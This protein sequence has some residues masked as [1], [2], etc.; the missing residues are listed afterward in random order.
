VKLFDREAVEET[1]PRV[2]IG[3]RQFVNR[4][5][6]VQLTRTWFADYS[7]QG[8]ST[9]VA[10]KTQSK[11]V[12]IHRAHELAAKLRRDGAPAPRQN[13][14]LT[15]L[16]RQYLTAQ[17][18]K[19]R[20]SKT[21]EKYTFVLSAFVAWASEHSSGQASSMTEDLFWQWHHGLILGGYKSSTREDHLTLVKQL[22]KWAAKTKRMERNPIE[23]AK[24]PQGE[25]DPQPCFE[26]AQVA[27]L[28]ERADAFERPLF[29]TLAYTGVRIGE[30]RDL[31]WQDVV[32]PPDRAG[33]ILVRSGG[34]DGT[35]KNRK[36]RRIPIAPELRPILEAMPRRGPRVFY[37]PPSKRY[38]HGDCPLNDS[39]VLQ[40]L[41]DL[42]ERC[43]FVDP[44]Q[45]KV[46]T[47]RHVFAS[48]CARNNV[49]YKYALTWL[50]HGSSRILDLYYRAF[51]AVADEAMRTIS[52]APIAE[53]HQNETQ[54]GSS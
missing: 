5:G 24:I 35:T 12:A 25:S 48:M 15:E 36:S 45:Y 8:R 17:L 39:T 43:G 37:S 10:L 50:G 34:S 3:R 16:A 20:K 30:A 18:Q 46:H 7:Y 54:K 4:Q 49:A 29:A 40:R 13:L 41:K 33:H 14:T 32:L 6:Q 11:S 31:L 28:L 42:C 19:G 52:Y 23:D 2:T 9:C 22:F 21:I 1:N 27:V 44:R 38:P 51:D 26:P 53:T 47:F